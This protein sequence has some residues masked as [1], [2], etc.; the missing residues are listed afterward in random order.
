MK[1]LINICISLA[2]LGLSVATYHKAPEAIHQHKLHQMAPKELSDPI[3]KKQIRIHRHLGGSQL[4]HDDIV[5][6]TEV[7]LQELPNMQAAPHLVALILETMIVETNMGGASYNY[8]Q[9][10]WKNYGIGQF[11]LTS[12]NDTL[13]WV[14]K[15]HPETHEAL[16]NY[17]NHELSFKDNVISNV[18][19]CIALISQYYLQRTKNSLSKKHLGTLAK[20]AQVW[21]I[22]YN[23]AAGSG[24]PSIYIQR[25]NRYYKAHPNS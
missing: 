7:I 3:Y 2:M 5:E 25:V 19:F 15:Y 16:M 13:N 23:T 17:Y 4:D 21:N 12:A 1:L 6:T 11:T 20:R 9:K 18:P 14:K 10:H 24:T 22:V 8:S